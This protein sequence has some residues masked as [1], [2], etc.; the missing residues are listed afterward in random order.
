MRAYQDVAH[1]AR[2]GLSASCYSL[3][4]NPTSSC[5]PDPPAPALPRLSWAGASPSFY[6]Y[7][8]MRSGSGARSTANSAC[9]RRNVSAMWQ[10][11]QTGRCVFIVSSSFCVGIR[12]TPPFSAQRQRALAGGRANATRQRP[13][14]NMRTPCPHTSHSRSLQPSM[15]L[16]LP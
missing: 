14:G 1:S 7:T 11:Q 13:Y 5:I 16:A 12:S 2:W 10:L 3:T 6:L 9:S 4:W 15:P 8:L